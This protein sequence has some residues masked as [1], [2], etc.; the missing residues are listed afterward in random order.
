[1]PFTFLSDDYTDCVEFSIPS[2]GMPFVFGKRP[3]IAGFND[4]IFSPGE[5][6]AAEGIAVAGVAIGKYGENTYAFNTYRDGNDEINNSPSINDRS[7]TT[8]VRR[9]TTEDRSQTTDDR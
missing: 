3:V 7:Q 4:S 8:E 5:W 9:Q 6:D 1:M 2:V